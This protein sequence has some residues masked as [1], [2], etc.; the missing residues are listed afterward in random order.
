MC[1]DYDGK[2]A[3][4]CEGSKGGIPGF[5]F[6]KRAVDC[7]NK[8]KVC[9]SQRDFEELEV[10]LLTYKGNPKTAEKVIDNYLKAGRI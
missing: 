2:C 1:S 8:K 6:Q 7:N 10:F 9:C 5:L 4:K 3:E